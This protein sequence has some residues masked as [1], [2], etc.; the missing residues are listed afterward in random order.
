[1]RRALSAAIAERHLLLDDSAFSLLEVRMTPDLRR[2]YVLWSARAGAEERSQR[3]L[4]RAAVPLRSAVAKLVGLKHTPELHFRCAS[5]SNEEQQLNDA[6][7]AIEAE[8][9]EEADANGGDALAEGADHLVGGA[10]FAVHHAAPLGN[11]A[12]LMRLLESIRPN[13]LE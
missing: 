11:E 6:F 10:G 13:K 12:D 1:M 5:V 7:L 9:L 8:R 3:E 2:A 4:A